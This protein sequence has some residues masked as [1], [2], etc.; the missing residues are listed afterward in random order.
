MTDLI[1]IQAGAELSESAKRIFNSA[2]ARFVQTSEHPFIKKLGLT[3]NVKSMDD[4]YADS[5]DFDELNRAVA[6]RLVMAAEFISASSR[7][8]MRGATSPTSPSGGSIPP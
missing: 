3:G 5:E 2:E 7:R 1:I 6:G 4:L 8:A